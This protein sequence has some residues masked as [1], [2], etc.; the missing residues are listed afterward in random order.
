MLEPPEL[1]ETV[2]RRLARPGALRWLLLLVVVGGF[3]GAL[4]AEI[5]VRVFT[6]DWH[7]VMGYV[8]Q[9]DRGW[10]G[11]VILW[12]AL[13]LAPVVQGLVGASLASLYRRPRRWLAALAVAVV[14]AIPIYL[15]SLTLVWLPGILLFMF[16]FLVSC[17]W[18]SDG[19]RELLAIDPSESADYVAAMVIASSAVLFLTSAAF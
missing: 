9:A 16:A 19:A 15:A 3:G 11:F 18:W 6:T 17:S 2:E 7:P 5:G 8:P 13:A 12:L 10:R 1:W 14:G 4:A